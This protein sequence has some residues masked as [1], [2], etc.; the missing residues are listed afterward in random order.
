MKPVPRYRPAAY[1][2]VKRRR[3]YGVPVAITGDVELERVRNLHQLRSYRIVSVL[4]IGVLVFVIAAMIVGTPPHEWAQQTAL[5]ALYGFAALC[6]LALAFS[7]RDDSSKRRN[8]RACAGGNRWY[9]PPSTSW[10]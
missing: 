3:E 6:A 4:R 9:S 10:R 5:V 8:R 7:R 1:P 2:A